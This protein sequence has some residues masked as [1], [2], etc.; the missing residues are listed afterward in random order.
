MNRLLCW[1]TAF[2]LSLLLSTQTKANIIL[3]DPKCGTAAGDNCLIFD[4]F[5]VFSMSFLEFNNSGSLQPTAQ[6]LYYIDSSPGKI[7]DDIV[8]ASSPAASINNSDI[9]PTGIDDAYSTPTS[10]GPDFFA[11]LAANEPDPLLTHDNIQGGNALMP[12]PNN[13]D[14]DADGSGDGTGPLALWDIE[15][16]V[17]TSFLGGEDLMFF[18]NLNETGT[19][20]QLAS[21]QDMLGWLRVYLTDSATGNSISFTLSGNNTAIPAIQS[22]AQTAQ[23][24]IL[25]TAQDEWAYIHGK[26]C[27]NELDGSV[28]ALSS[29]SAAGNPANGKTVNQNLGANA[30]AFGLWNQDL[31]TALYSGAYDMMSVD[32]RMGYIES[33][34]EQLFIRAAQVGTEIPEPSMIL[35]FSIALLL[36]TYRMAIKSTTGK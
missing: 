3:P 33:G 10:G 21:G 17:L 30:A 7:K 26:I 16:S 22:Y 14:V 12:N 20:D 4:D 19:D 6:D 31:N 8:I 25:P 29:C 1:V 28:I 9:S 11:M 13:I 24:N 27:V 32:M 23:D 35:I 2:C 36:L 18:F 15:T 5:T 34:Y